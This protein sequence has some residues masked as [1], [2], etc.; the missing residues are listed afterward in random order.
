MV[1]SVDQGK[2]FYNVNR[3]LKAIPV[4]FHGGSISKD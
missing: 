2:I 3:Y 4:I 1:L